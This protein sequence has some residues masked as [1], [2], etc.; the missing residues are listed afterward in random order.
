VHAITTIVL[1]GARFTLEAYGC[2]LL[3]V[4]DLVAGRANPSLDRLSL[5]PYPPGMPAPRHV[6][7]FLL[8]FFETDESGHATLPALLDLFQEAAWNH[9]RSYRLSVPELRRDGV[10]WVL[11]RLHV[12][13]DRYPAWGDEIAVETWPSG[14]HGLRFFRDFVYRD[15]A[16]ATFGRG[17]TAFMMLDLRT[18]RP[19][20]ITDARIGFPVTPERALEDTFPRLEEV[21]NPGRSA[22][23]R[24]RRDDLDMNRHVNTTS[25]V[26]WCLESVPEGLWESAEPAS[27]Q[28]HYRE[29]CFLGDD[30][31]AS[32]EVRPGSSAECLHSVSRGPARSATTAAVAVS[33]WRPRE[34]SPREQ[35]TAPTA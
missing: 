10:M 25:Y 7:R 23:F 9:A 1:R 14:I 15:A 33:R 5:P 28:I 21:A 34:A 19:T 31:T 22:A 3:A 20:K 27:L 30:V 17:T 6:E 32:V 35:G 24:V 11:Y 29:E 4:K 16:G 12:E 13:V 18:R 26:R 2:P 8:R